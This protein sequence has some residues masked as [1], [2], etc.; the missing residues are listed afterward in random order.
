MRR[1]AAVLLLAVFLAACGQGD[2]GSQE[3]SA[4]PNSADVE[5]VQQMI[6][7]HEQAVEMAKL[8]D[9][10][11]QRPQLVQLSQD[12]VS[13]QRNEIDT[14]TAWLEEWGEEPD[15]GGMDHGGGH[16]DMAM[17]GVM[18]EEEMEGLMALEGRTFD[19][20]FSEMMIAHHEGAIEM[21]ETEQDEGSLPKV[22]DLAERIVEAQEAEIEQMQGW[23]QD[24][25]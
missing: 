24:W 2:D 21:A 18:T 22:K 6:P 20:A 12:I 7:H 5:F 9:D 3:A 16:D 1:I 4:E 23:L 10:R 19:L 17:P 25:R 14:M 8:V 13:S 15:A 11:T